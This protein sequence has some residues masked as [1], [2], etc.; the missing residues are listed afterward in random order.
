MAGKNGNLER[1]ENRRDKNPRVCIYE[2]SLRFGFGANI[3][4]YMHKLPNFQY[5]SPTALVHFND[6]RKVCL[7]VL[8]T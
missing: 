1:E 3:D 2:K 8:R 6:S 5:L 4:R 7:F